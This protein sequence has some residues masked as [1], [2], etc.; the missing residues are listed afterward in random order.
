[1]KILPN[2]LALPLSHD[3]RS[4][5]LGIKTVPAV[6]DLLCTNALEVRKFDTKEQHA[7]HIGIHYGC[8][9]KAICK[10]DPILTPYEVCVP[11]FTDVSY[12]SMQ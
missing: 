5:T 8:W 11:V 12:A 1:M 7:L 9:G 2:T 6:T 10:N 4:A 3:Q